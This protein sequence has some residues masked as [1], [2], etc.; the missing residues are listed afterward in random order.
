MILVGGEVDRASL[1]NPPPFVP[2]V[3]ALV[4]Q[5]SS[6]KNI[7]T[8]RCP[9]RHADLSVFCENK[10][11]YAYLITRALTKKTR[12][13]ISRYNYRRDDSLISLSLFGPLPVLSSIERSKNEFTS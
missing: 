11:E 12:D 4:V 3:F 6:G 13:F 10:G 1:H 2:R 9:F 7:L 5:R 8:I